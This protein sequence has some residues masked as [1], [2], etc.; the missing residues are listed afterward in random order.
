[1]S[2]GSVTEHDFDPREVGFSYS[3]IDDIRGGS[4]EENAALA[5]TVLAGEKNVARDIILLNSAAGIVAHRLSN[6][7]AE[8]DRSFVARMAEAVQV[9]AHS[10]D[11]GAASAKLDAWV[12]ATR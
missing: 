3:S 7:P 8:R 2:R 9:S 12:A 11:S 5:R 4:P 1:V 6:N 10:I